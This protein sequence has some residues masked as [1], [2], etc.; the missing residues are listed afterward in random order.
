MRKVKLRTNK[1]GY[2]RLVLKKKKKRNLSKE[3]KLK[4]NKGWLKRTI[5]NSPKK[6]VQGGNGRVVDVS[7]AGARQVERVLEGFPSGKQTER[8]S[9]DC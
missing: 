6:K 4:E 2:H 8:V 1:N 3:K 7:V 9:Q 5:E